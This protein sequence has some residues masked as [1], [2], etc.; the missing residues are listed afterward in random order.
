M[1]CTYGL[2]KIGQ[3]IYPGV[4]YVGELKLIDIGMPKEMVNRLAGFMRLIEENWV[5]TL[6][7]P[8]HPESHKG[9]F[10]HLLLIGASPGKTGAIA[11]ASESAVRAGAG[12]V[13]AGVPASLNPIL[14]NKLTEAMTLPLDDDGEGYLSHKSWL[15]I[16]DNLSKFSAIAIG[17]GMDTKPST[18]E[19]FFKLLAEVS[20]PMVIDADGLNILASN[21][22]ATPLKNKK[23]VLT[24]H[25]GEAGRL[26][27]I[28]SHQVQE[29]RLRSARKIAEK[30]GA[31]TLLKGARSIISAPDGRLAVN[32]T[33]NPGMASGGTGD[34]LLAQGVEP[35]ESACA[36][37]WLH[38]RAGDIA[39][40]EKGTISLK[41]TDILDK[42]PLTFLF[43][44]KDFLFFWKKEKEDKRK[45]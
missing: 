10:G 3:V 20:L 32:P 21:P 4:Y 42:L 34:V 26:L 23:V 18:A 16:K 5:E 12:L 40:K 9:N 15:K 38:G 37:A 28:S 8:R 35:F 6:I 41:A 11:M 31:V 27:G 17:P 14:E 43:S 36:G 29:D 1:T 13:T 2:R 25:P 19:L 30:T 45:P 24:P 7:P 22:Q 33:G 39:E 44:R